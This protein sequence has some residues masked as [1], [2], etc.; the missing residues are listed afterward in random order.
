AI[1]LLTEVLVD[2]PGVRSRFVN[3]ARLLAGFDH[4]HIVPVYDYVEDGDVCALVMERLSGGT[5]WQRVQAGGMTQQDAVAIALAT[6]SSLDYAHARGV[7]HRDVKPDNLLFSSR[8]VLKV[9]D[10]GIAKVVGAEHTVATQTGETM[11]TP[12]YMAPE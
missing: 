6:A 7:L 10:F 12:V 8:G 9:T 2:T 3:E 1:K 4:P 11:G 5:V